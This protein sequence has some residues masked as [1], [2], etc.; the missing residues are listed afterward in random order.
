MKVY[1]EIT[2]H[3]L[4]QILKRNPK[5]NTTTKAMNFW[6]YLFRRFIN[7]WEYNWNRVRYSYSRDWKYKITDW[8]HCFIY[9]REYKLEYK[10]ITYFKKETPQKV[11]HREKYIDEQFNV[12]DMKYINSWYLDE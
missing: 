7:K 4:E 1:V 11:H 12:W 6:T 9:S 3:C 5:K 8:I 10:L 2:K